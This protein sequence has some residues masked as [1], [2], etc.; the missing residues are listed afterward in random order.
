MP[1]T[2]ILTSNHSLGEEELALARE[3]GAC[4]GAAL[5]RRLGATLGDDGSA[6]NQAGREQARKILDAAAAADPRKIARADLRRAVSLYAGPQATDREKAAVASK[7][8]EFLNKRQ[9]A[10]AT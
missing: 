6:E 8:L 9:I 7:V 10:I 5:A 1:N 2:E 4:E 3:G